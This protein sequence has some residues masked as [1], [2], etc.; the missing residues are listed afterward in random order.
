MPEDEYIVEYS[1][2]Y[3]FL[4]L[5]PLTRQKLNISV[6]IVVLDPATNSCFGDAFSQFILQGFLGYDDVLMSSIKSLAENEDNK[7]YLRNVVTGAHYHFVSRWTSSSSYFVAALVMMIF[8][9]Q[10]PLGI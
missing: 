5:S 10:Q 2:E 9:S 4:R 7:G 3:G 8:V 1:L 6:M